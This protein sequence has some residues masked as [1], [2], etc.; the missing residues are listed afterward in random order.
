MKKITIDPI[1][2]LEGHGKIDIFVNDADEVENVYLEIP[3]LRGFEKFCEG[4]P[5]EELPR[6]VPKICGV[7]PGVHHMASTK[8]VDMVFGVKPTETAKKLR[9]IFYQAHNIHSHIAHFYA[10][11]APDFIVG[12]DADKSSRNILGVIAKVGVETGK[13]VIE[14]RA[15]AQKIQAML[16][17]HQTHVVMGL[18]GGVSKKMTKE[19]R[20][21]AKRYAAELLEFAKF[22]NKIFEDVI[23]KNKAYVDLILS[24]TYETNLYSMGLVDENNKMNMYDGKV[25][26]VD[27]E[28]KEVYKFKEIE[29]LDYIAEHVEPWT[30]LKFPYLK[31]IGWKGFTDGKGTS[32][33]LVAPLGRLNAADGLTTP[34]AQAEYERMY[35]TLGKKPVTKMLAQHWARVIELLYFA[36]NLV[37]LL[38]D[39]SI[40]SDDIRNIPQEVKGEG[41]GIVEAQRGTLIHHYIT[42]EKAM[43]K[44]ANIIVATAFNY[45]AM[46]LTLK[47]AAKKLA[48]KE[49][50]ID[51]K[52]LNM[53]EMAFRAFDPCFGCATHSLPGTMPLIVKIKNKKG[54]VID[55]IRRD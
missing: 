22:T 25:R 30:Y 20:E 32:L 28:G 29:Y 34:L 36:E 52:I 55:I 4:R 46:T 37:E 14:S 11:A 38:N 48:K 47:N 8:A 27:T 5:V 45:G 26:V 15:K 40:L 33:T 50:K 9:Q 3:E 19:E 49:G 18:P 31:K 39:D 42:D 10:L 43:V 44:K 7:C 17:G 23:L 21:E 16:A 41:I 54:E 53:I 35:K 24:D 6:I 13:K 1:T 12:V 2:R 51:D